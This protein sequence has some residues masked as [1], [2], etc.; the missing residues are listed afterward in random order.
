[1]VSKTTATMSS[2]GGPTFSWSSN[3]SYFLRAGGKI[4]GNSTEKTGKK[5]KTKW[6]SFRKSSNLI[7]SFSRLKSGPTGTSVLLH[8]F[9]PYVSSI[10]F[11]R[12]STGQ[13]ANNW[14]SIESNF[15][16]LKQIQKRQIKC[17]TFSVRFRNFS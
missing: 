12:I 9:I 11:W 15:E 1:M 2:C 3:R 14:N 17:E 4:E 8:V 6:A 13:S 5:N 16:I 7:F 10:R